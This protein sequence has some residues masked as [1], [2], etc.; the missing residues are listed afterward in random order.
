MNLEMRDPNSHLVSIGPES[1]HN[2]F[3]QAASMLSVVNQDC[4]KAT[5]YLIVMIKYGKRGRDTHSLV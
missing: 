2:N 4:T 3:F 5:V 1:V